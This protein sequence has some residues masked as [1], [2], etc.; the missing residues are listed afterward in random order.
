M[1][2]VVSPEGSICNLLTV[3]GRLVDPAVN[4]PGL[5]AVSI[6]ALMPCRVPSLP[7]AVD[8]I[9]MLFRE[10]IPGCIENVLAGCG[11]VV[12]DVWVLD[13]VA[14]GFD[15]IEDAERYWA[16][17]R[18]APVAM[19]RVENPETAPIIV[20]LFMSISWADEGLITDTVMLVREDSFQKLFGPQGELAPNLL[21][22]YR[23]YRIARKN[24]DTV[25]I[26]AE[27]IA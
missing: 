16:E 4:P 8:T 2:L 13:S 18:R 23:H 3:A 7:I 26:E 6:R 21:K 27:I 10:I 25:L 11:A 1:S 12:T 5:S 20:Q 17:M 14:T 9:T 15:T 22:H 19:I 24:G